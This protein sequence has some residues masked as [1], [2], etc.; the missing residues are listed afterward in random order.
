MRMRAGDGGLHPER[1]DG[2]GQPGAQGAQLA[3]GAGHG[4]VR[5]GGELQREPVRLAARVLGEVVVEPRQ[6]VLGAPRRRA[7]GLEQHD[8]LLDADGPRVAAL[9]ARPRGQHPF[10]RH[11]R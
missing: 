8:L 7:V 2:L 1:A 3:G 10:D 5:V 9:P 4:R 11:A 6:H